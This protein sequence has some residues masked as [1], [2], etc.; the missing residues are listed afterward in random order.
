MI[1]GLRI[2][3]GRLNNGKARQPYEFGLKA[4]FA[5]TAHKDLIVGAR[6]FPGNSYDGDTLA[7]QLEQTAILTDL[8]HRQWTPQ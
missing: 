6:S 1:R 5:V 2:I 7:E 8:S 3:Q 4:S